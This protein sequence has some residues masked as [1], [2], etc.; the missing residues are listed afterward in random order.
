MK[1][2]IIEVFSLVSTMIIESKAVFPIDTCT[3]FFAA[4]ESLYNYERD[5]SPDLKISKALKL[6][7]RHLLK[8]EKK[9][10]PLS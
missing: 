4:Y 2:L 6:L 9:S 10:K 3:K 7:A 5:N 1:N 8:D